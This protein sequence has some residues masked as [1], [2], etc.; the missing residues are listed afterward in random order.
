MVVLVL[1]VVVAAGLRPVRRRSDL[2]GEVGVRDGAGPPPEPA[3]GEEPEAALARTIDAA[4]VDLAAGRTRNAVVAIW[5]QLEALA[6][7][8][9]FPFHPADSPAEFAGRACD[10]IGWDRNAMLRLAALYREARFSTHPLSA[11]QAV[12]ARQCLARLRADLSEAAR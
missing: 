6:R 3:P 7:S 11:E 1:A 2:T 5:L 4:L 9:H 10:A 8:A 12:A